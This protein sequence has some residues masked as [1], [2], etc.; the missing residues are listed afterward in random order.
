MEEDSCG[1]KDLVATE[2]FSLEN[3]NLDCTYM[4]TVLQLQNSLVEVLIMS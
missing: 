1:N 4:I 2:I 3:E